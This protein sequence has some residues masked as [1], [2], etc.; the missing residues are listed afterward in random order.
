M[1]RFMIVVCMLLAAADPVQAAQCGSTAIRS[2]CKG[3]NG[4]V[5]TG[6]NG[7]GAYNKNTGAAAGYNKNTGTARAYNTSTGNT[8]TYN[9]T[10]GTTTGVQTAVVRGATVQAA[11]HVIVPRVVATGTTVAAAP[12]SPVRPLLRRRLAARGYAIERTE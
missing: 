1:T 5:G 7:A 4:A 12:V 10:T 8:A 9:T 6:P 3:A 11:P 2:G